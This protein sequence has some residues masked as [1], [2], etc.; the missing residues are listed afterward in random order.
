MSMG[1]L[2][3]ELLRLADRPY[4]AI[5]PFMVLGIKELRKFIWRGV[6]AHETVSDL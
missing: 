2:G 4:L 6:H 1:I 3:T 5:A